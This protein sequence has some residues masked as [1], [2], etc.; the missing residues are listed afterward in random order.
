MNVPGWSARDLEVISRLRQLGG[1]VTPEAEARERIRKQVLQ[2]LAEEERRAPSKRRRVLAEVL[3]AAVALVIALGGLGL[4][5]SKNSLPG[6]VLYGVKRAGESA[7][8][9]LTFGDSAKAEKHLLFA[10]HRLDELEALHDAQAAHYSDTLADF[11]HE[12]TLGTA[13]FTQ[14]AVQGGGGHLTQ[15]ESWASE[16]QA[17]L[18]QV[19]SSLPGGSMDSYYA[20]SG[21]LDRIS[22][23]AQRLTTRL[24]CAQITTGVPDELGAVPDTSECRPPGQDA[25]TASQPPLPLPPPPVSQPAAPATTTTAPPSTT[26]SQSQPSGSVPPSS[27][28]STPPVFN[29]PVPAPTSP[30]TSGTTT[31]APPPSLSIPPL[32]PGLPGVGIG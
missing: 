3:A 9:G 16:Q 32:F 5:L 12:A 14:L 4:V 1:T 10:S 21:L 28:M 13:Q 6:D 25:I 15:L 19:R 11:Q 31:S 18:T 26:P 7:Q 2:R 24:N 29:P 30:R 17:K 23:R 22:T 8:L 20:A 27:G